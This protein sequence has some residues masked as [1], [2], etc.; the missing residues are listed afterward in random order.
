[1]SNPEYLQH[2]DAFANWYRQQPGVKHVNVLTDIMK[3]L[4]KSLHGDDPAWYRLPDSREL[5]A[6]YL[7]LY[8]FSLPFGLDLNNQINVKKS[9][10]KMTVSLD[11]I[12]S[13][14]LLALDRSAQEWLVNNTPEY[15]HVAGA[16]SSLM[17]ANIGHRN[18]NAMLKGTTAALFVISLILVISLRS[19]RIGL[20]SLIPNL[21][22]IGMAFGLWALFVGQVGLGLSVV[23]GMTIGIVV[24]DTVHFLSKY[25][26]ARREQGLDVEGAVRY[27]F[28][29]VGTALWVTTLVLMLGFGVLALSHF[30][31][32]ASMGLLTAV[33]I[34]LALFADFFFLPPLLM[35]IGDKE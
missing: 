26:R 6:Q 28:A 17:F 2:L 31:I 20:I 27:A 1:M 10:S 8:E 11:T 3:R 18:I 15:M 29:T 22:P 21:M 5:S 13:E 19:L 23:S 4:N 30:E 35:K 25:L 24:D 9:A 32:N 16:S 12:S 34:G 7:L 14:T 33:T